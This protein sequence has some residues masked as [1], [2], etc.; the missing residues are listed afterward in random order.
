MNNSKRVYTRSLC[1]N[2]STRSTK[3]QD[4]RSRRQY[5]NN[6][7]SR[8]VQRGR[9]LTTANNPRSATVFIPYRTDGPLFRRQQRSARPI[10][11]IRYDP[12]SQ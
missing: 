12:C 4:L 8:S 2:S 11:A 6:V 5:N 1:S 9:F 3:Q 10:L 7:F